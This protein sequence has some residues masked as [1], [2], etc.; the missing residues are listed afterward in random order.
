MDL[1]QCTVKLKFILAFLFVALFFIFGTL[2]SNTPYH[3]PNVTYKRN[4]PG[5]RVTFWWAC[6]PRGHDKKS[7]LKSG[8][9]AHTKKNSTMSKIHQKD[10]EDSK[11]QQLFSPSD[12]LTKKGVS[13]Y[14]YHFLV[15]PSF[16]F[17]FQSENKNVEFLFKNEKVYLIIQ[18]ELI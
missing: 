13:M 8:L 6:R 2:C 9:A 4:F 14:N 3:S 7:F 15:M 17:F 5:K 18:L 16:W 12:E 11:P 1:P 10:F